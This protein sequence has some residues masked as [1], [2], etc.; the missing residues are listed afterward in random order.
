MAE[1]G[2]AKALDPAIVDD[3]M[4]LKF[5]AAELATP[6]TALAVKFNLPEEQIKSKLQPLISHGLVRVQGM[7]DSPSAVYSV[8]QAG[9]EAIE[10]TIKKGL[11]AF[12]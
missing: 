7:V 3:T 4:I 5:I 11:S 9:A 1:H 6:S 8:T 2:Q 10:R 12:I